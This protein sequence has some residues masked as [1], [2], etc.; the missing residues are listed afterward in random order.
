MTTTHHYKQSYSPGIWAILPFVYAAWSDQVLSP[1]EVKTIRKQVI[2]LSFLTKEDILV[3]EKWSKP[4]YPPTYDLFKNW[5]IICYEEASKR[6]KNEQSLTNLGLALARKN[7]GVFTEQQKNDLLVLEKTF[8]DINVSSY[9]EL[10]VSTPV[11]NENETQSSFSIKEMQRFLDGNFADVKAKILAVLK[12]PVFETTH[13]PVKEDYR[14]KVLEW[15]HLLAQQGFG[16]KAYPEA[17]GGQDRMAD[18]ISIFENLAYHDL[19]LTIKFGV[20]FGLW[21]GSVLWLGTQKHHDKYLEDIGSLAL[22]GCFAMT[23][24]GHGSNVRGLE[25][26]ATFDPQTDEFIIHSP[27]KESGKEYIGNALHGRAASVFAQLIV[28]GENHGVHALVVPLRDENNQLL[29]GVTIQDNGYKLGLNGVDNGRIWFN[30]VR[31]PRDQLLNR[32]GNVSKTGEYTSPID[33]PGKRFFTMLGTLVGGRVC[34]PRAGLSAA[35]KALTIAIKYANKR[36]QFVA[37]ASMK[38]TLILDYPVHQRRLLPLLAKVYAIHFSLD[39]LADRYLSQTEEDAREVETLAAA[40]KSYATWFTTACIQE[41]REACGGKGYL[42]ENQFANLK[43][44]SDIFTTFEGDNTVLMQLVAKG[45]LTQFKQAFHDDG[46]MVLLRHLGQRVNTVLTEQN[47]F[48]IRQVDA[49]HLLNIEFQMEAF[50]FRERRLLWSLSQRMRGHIKN[51][52]TTTEAGLI[53]QTHM[54]TLAKAFAERMTLESFENA[55]K[56]KA[57]RSNFPVL[58]KIRSLYALHTI[59]KHAAWYMEQDYIA[60][61]KSKAIRKMVDQ[62]C[63]ELRPDASA[64]TDAFGIPNHLIAAPIVVGEK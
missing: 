12:D 4:M 64:L 16:N 23:E 6:S 59:E 5:E 24:T 61:V 51:G 8:L 3:V 26:T 46:N 42:A 7:G 31:V 36:R 2:G 15:C 29:A 13:I 9:Q 21:G 47:P 60:S 27:R 30:Q 10:F 17:N 40:I 22:P 20:Q 49:D 63:L 44:G 41:C 56:K 28:N 57:G 34:V 32:F 62:L 45:L 48:I 33:N 43:S 54:V 39:H 55:L 38:E 25:T 11:L 18:Y 1:S 58:R 35:K 19:S 50:A 37:S 14:E 52:K 53:C